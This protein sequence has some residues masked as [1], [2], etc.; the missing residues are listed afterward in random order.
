MSQLKKLDT[1]D[2]SK[3]EK[4]YF[5]QKGITGREFE[6]MDP[7]AQKEWKEEMKNPTYWKNDRGEKYTNKR[8]NY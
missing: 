3:G 2:L 7:E 8:F 5:A 1:N 4:C 6:R